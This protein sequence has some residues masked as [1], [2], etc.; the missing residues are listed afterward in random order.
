MTGLSGLFE[1]EGV[2]GGDKVAFNASGELT[3]AFVSNGE[4]AW[5]GTG[6]PVRGNGR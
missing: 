4:G 5:A 2:V 3:T 6:E 1:S